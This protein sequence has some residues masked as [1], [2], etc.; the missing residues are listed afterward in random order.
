MELAGR[1]L[2]QYRLVEK[3][4][5]GGMG[6]VFRAEDT[7]LGRQVA[8]KLLSA[9]S[10]A[11]PRARER[12]L[13]EARAVAALEHQHICLLYEFAEADGQ[14][15]L[16]MQLVEGETLRQALRSGPLSEART[17]AIVTAVASAL[18]AAHKRD[19]LHRDVK[20]ENV[21]LGRDGSIKLSDFGIARYAGGPT[22]T[23][24]HA[25]VG[26]P[27]YAAPEIVAKRCQA[28][29]HR[30]GDHRHEVVATSVPESGERVVFGEYRDGRSPVR[31]DIR[32]ERGLEPSVRCAKRAC[33]PPESLADEPCADAFLICDFRR[34]VYG[35]R[36]LAESRRMLVDRMKHPSLT[37]VHTRM[38]AEIAQ[39]RA[40]ASCASCTSPCASIDVRT[41]LGSTCGRM[42]PTSAL[43][44]PR[45]EYDAR[46]R[47][48]RAVMTA[49]GADL[50]LVDESE[51]VAYLTGYGPRGTLHQVVLV[52]L[53]GDPLMVVREADEG[54]FLDSAWFSRFVSYADDDDT[55]RVV[56]DA[57]H[58]MGAHRARVAVELDSHF[59]PVGRFERLRAALPDATFVD[60]S[61]VLWEQ[62]LVKSQAEIACHRLAAAAADSAMARVLTS[63]REG[64]S[65]R[66]AAIAVYDAILE[67]GADNSY[68]AIVTSG[69]RAE[70]MHG[71]LTDRVLSAGDTLHTELLPQVRGYTSRL[72]RTTIV[73]APTERQRDTAA[74]LISIQDRQL[75][76]L[77]PGADPAAIDA[78]CRREVLAAGLRA[79]YRNVTGYSVGY[80][81]MVAVPRT[82][83]F[84]RTFT[85]SAAWELKVGMVFHMYVW[86]AGMAF[87]ETMLITV[88][89]AE[90]LGASKRELYSV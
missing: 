33:R 57:V 53:D 87:S 18:A 78:L 45:A 46:I 88:G 8:L 50:L 24:T 37:I 36:K 67:H 64:V 68:S 86:A 59:M 17:R 76:A 80:N 6:A 16:A 22:L 56:A 12:L 65:E 20:S 3:L 5:E 73:G 28:N 13:A 44:F 34:A 7:R 48:V 85:P 75:A 14:P 90:R 69:P 10:L 58:G 21:L 89:G 51:H 66:V 79:S 83:D 84:T 70:A 63:V 72:M 29:G 32:A 42:T 62:R 15:F 60:F 11:D 35:D 74:R 1:S 41:R 61:R 47:A 27:A 19:I 52:P 43:P 26:S 9:P 31:A 55:A 82:S 23:A 2:A 4:G 49:R 77:R 38:V 30:G 81:P 39:H 54:T 71:N 25:M 40:R